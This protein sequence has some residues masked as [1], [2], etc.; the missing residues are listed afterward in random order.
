MSQLRKA[1]ENE[2]ALDEFDRIVFESIVEKVI[3]GGYDEDG[4]PTPYKLTFVLKCNQDL[5]VDDAKADYQANQ[6]GKKVS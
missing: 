4:N 2:D 5:K 6:K 1:L 3:V